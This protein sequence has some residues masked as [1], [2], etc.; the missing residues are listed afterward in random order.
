MDRTEDVVAEVNC[1]VRAFRKDLIRLRWALPDGDGWKPEQ[2]VK[3][4]SDE[5][6]KAIKAHAPRVTDGMDG[7]LAS[8]QCAG[9]LFQKLIHQ[10]F[11][12]VQR[13]QGGEQ[14]P[15]VAGVVG[16]I[17]YRPP[18][19]SEQDLSSSLGGTEA[20]ALRRLIMAVC[21]RKWEDVWGNALVKN[22]GFES[23][24]RAHAHRRRHWLR[25][26]LSKGGE[27]ED[28]SSMWQGHPFTASE[29]YFLLDINY[30]ST[31][32]CLMYRPYA[33]ANLAYHNPR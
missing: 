33:I 27:F 11:E 9:R 18:G 21:R 5:A 26:L 25:Q 20:G 14:T 17:L 31:E 8:G 22:V 2:S 6:L 28:F 3:S 1:I 12:L 4:H 24:K 16:R 13:V 32:E 29:G 23:A 30:G 15:V 19:D 10:D 7:R